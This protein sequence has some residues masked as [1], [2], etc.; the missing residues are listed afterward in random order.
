[1]ARGDDRS[2][3]IDL[4]ASVV[5]F[6]DDEPVALAWLYSDRQGQRAETLM[7]ATRRDRRGRGLATL[8]KIESSRRAA[9]LGV[10]RIVTGNDLDN[11]PM[12]AINQKLGFVESEVA[13]SYVKHLTR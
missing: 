12:L 10:G 3:L 2:P 8:A 13:E 7:A 1:M 6:E 4:E 11:A 5:V 9:A